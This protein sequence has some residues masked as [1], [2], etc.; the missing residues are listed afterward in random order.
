M[1]MYRVSLAFLARRK[2]SFFCFLPFP[3]FMSVE[4]GGHVLVSFIMVYQ[5]ID[6]PLKKKIFKN[7]LS[8]IPF[9]S[10]FLSCIFF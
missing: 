5:D 8:S 2:V 1:H 7:T 10:Y 9:L 4:R 3:S 6:I